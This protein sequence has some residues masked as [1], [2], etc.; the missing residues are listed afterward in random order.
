MGKVFYNLGYLATDETIE[1][2]VRDFIAPFVGQTRQKTKDQ[3]A[4]ARGKVLII[5]NPFQML[6]G[7]YELEALQ[8]LITCL[9]S[10]EYAG[11]L[12]VILVGY[13]EEMGLLLHSCPPL[14]TLFPNEVKFSRLKS[15][16]CLKLLSRELD[17]LD[18]SAPFLK[19]QSCEDYGI[20]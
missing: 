5:D 2:S 17:K 6:K 12:V 4:R 19:D 10:D 16:D 1:Y 13:A 11:K 8:E 18:V 9:P 20:L 15:K 14:A 3:L 7:P